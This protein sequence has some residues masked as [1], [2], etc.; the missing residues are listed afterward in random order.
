MRLL[1]DEMLSPRLAEQ[2]RA[3]GHDVVA[4]ADLPLSLGASDED[5][6]LIAS[7]QGRAVVTRDLGDYRGLAR[8]AARVGSSHAGVLLVSDRTFPEANPRT[9][10][11]LFTSLLALLE[12]DTDIEGREYWLR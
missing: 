7:A 4:V 2:L 3:R 5:V 9:I 8:A 6:L 12:A 10:G 1:L 11:R